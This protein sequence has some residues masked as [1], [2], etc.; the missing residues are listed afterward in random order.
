MLIRYFYS[1]IDKRIN[2]FEKIIGENRYFF[3]SIFFIA[4][5]IDLFVLA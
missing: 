1:K 2:R 4:E 5:M 3:G